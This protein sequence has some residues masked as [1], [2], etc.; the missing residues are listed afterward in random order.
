MDCI[1]EKRCYK[2]GIIKSIVFFRADKKAIDGKCPHCK[3]CGGGPI[4]KPKR[5]PEEKIERRRER[6]RI[7]YRADDR[8]KNHNRADTKR[9]VDNISNRYA[10]ALVCYS[11]KIPARAVTQEQIEKKREEVIKKRKERL[12]DKR[13]CPLCGGGKSSY[14]EKCLKCHLKIVH[15]TKK[16]I[17]R[18]K[19][20]R[21]KKDSIRS[22][23]LHEQYIKSS[24]K[25][26]FG[27]KHS[28]CNDLLIQLKRDQLKIY[29]ELKEATNGITRARDSR[30]SANEQADNSRD[31]Q[32]GRGASEDS[33]LFSD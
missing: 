7:Y 17:E 11:L 3:E 20:E 12:I 1:T 26:Q 22:S 33:C 16:P 2:C 5:T 8:K 13:K 4:K 29:R 27:L 30:T 24:L 9:M 14:V 18:Y 10:R 31:N 15:E 28:E 32:T 6:A 25:H 23:N 21:R 19:E